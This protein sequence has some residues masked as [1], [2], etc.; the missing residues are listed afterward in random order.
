MILLSVAMDCF[1]LFFGL[2]LKISGDPTVTW[3]LALYMPLRVVGY[4]LVFLCFFGV[5][6]AICAGCDYLHSCL[7]TW[8]EEGGASD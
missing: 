1:M 7:V 2:Y 6:V 5:T 3:A 4:P 8:C